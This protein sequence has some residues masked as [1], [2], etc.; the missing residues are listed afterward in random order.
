MSRQRIK[1]IAAALVCAIILSTSSPAAAS[2]SVTVEFAYSGVVLGGV[3]LFVYFG[4]S[5]EIPFAGRN[6]PTAL[7][8]IREGRARLG[9]PLPSLPLATDMSGAPGPGGAL[10]IDLL[11]WRF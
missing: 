1:L 4:G 10:H 6:I 3:G 8:E 11:H 9:V 5:W 2:V 7:L